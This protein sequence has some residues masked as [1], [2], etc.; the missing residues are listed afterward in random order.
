MVVEVVSSDLVVSS[1]QICLRS[2]SDHPRCS[3]VDF[4]GGMF[5][6][7]QNLSRGRERERKCEREIDLVT[8]DYIARSY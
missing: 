3:L 7:V 2:E 6:I 1:N 4:I 8:T 5:S